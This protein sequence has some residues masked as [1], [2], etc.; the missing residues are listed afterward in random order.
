M[1]KKEKKAASNEQRLSFYL[2]GEGEKWQEACKVLW[3]E[4]KKVLWQAR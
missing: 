4:A 1:M 3:Q 2:L